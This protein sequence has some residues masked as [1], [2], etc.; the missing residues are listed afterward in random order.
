MIGYRINSRELKRRIRAHDHDWL[1]RAKSGEEPEWGDIKNVFVRIQHF[2]CGYCERPMPRPQRRTGEDA[3]RELPRCPG[4]ETGRT[5]GTP[6][7]H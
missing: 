5:L 4:I 7:K 1:D 6:L 2:K 3:T